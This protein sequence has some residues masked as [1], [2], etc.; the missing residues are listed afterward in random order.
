MKK[1]II[2][3]ILLAT[4][5][6]TFGCSTC[7]ITKGKQRVFAKNLDWK[8]ESGM[9]MVNKRNVQKTAFLPSAKMP[10]TWTSK[11][12]SI[13]I[14]PSGA[15]AP[16]GGM[17]EAGLVIEE[18]A[19]FATKY[20]AADHRPSIDE[21][22]WIQYQLDNCKSID[23]VMATDNLIR[24]E[25]YYWVSHYMVYDQQGNALTV[26]AENGRMIFNRI[27]KDGAQVLTNHTYAQSIQKLKSK[28]GFGGKDSIV[29]TSKS[30][31]RFCTAAQMIK[32]YQEE[33]NTMPAVDYAFTILK[34][35]A[36][37]ETEWSIV[38]DVQNKVIHY[39]TAST[40]DVKYIKFSSVDFS[41]STPNKYV[42]IHTNKK[43]NLAKHF[44][45]LTPEVNNLMIDRVVAD[46]RK[47]KICTHIT[48]IE[49][50]K[51]KKYPQ[52]FSCVGK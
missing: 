52:T 36:Q 4:T 34:T 6:N 38:Y 44:K 31:D 49:I 16:C 20:P 35:I 45:V 32:K 18:S 22:Q 40:P 24:I 15:D 42:D 23:E 33:D 14:N 13:T 50:E 29:S 2:T 28:V 26:D 1:F 19:L 5:Y 7:A 51:L 43:G 48:T 9:I 10:A 21:I 39:R 25:G 47:Q 17:N 27:D 41:C 46:W 37:K 12:G 8:W 11:Y 3:F 30:L